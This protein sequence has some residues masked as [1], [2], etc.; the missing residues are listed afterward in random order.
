[1][2]RLAGKITDSEL[3]VM[4]VLWAAGEALPL[5]EIRIKVREKTG[6]EDSTVKTLVHR[7]HSKD[8]VEQEKREVFYYAPC[9]TQAAYDDYV[10][11]TLIDKLHHG[12][13]KK[14]IASLV[15]SK[16]LSPRDIAELRELLRAE[17]DHE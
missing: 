12:S 9:I 13:A 5:A 6:W 16:K 8:V 1:M 11:Q 3:E 4:R 10:T 17:E 2:N 15:T 7:L 14:L